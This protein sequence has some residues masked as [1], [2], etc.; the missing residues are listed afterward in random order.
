MKRLKFGRQKLTKRPNMVCQSGG[1]ART[2]LFVLLCYQAFS[3]SL[4]FWQQ[5][6]QAQ[7]W[8]GEVVV[9][10]PKQNSPAHLHAL[11]TKRPTLS[12][13][14]SKGMPQCLI[15]SFN[16]ARADFPSQTNQ[17]FCSEDDFFLHR[18]EPSFPLLFDQLCVHQFFRWP[19]DCFARTPP[20][21][22]SLKLFPFPIHRE[23]SFGVTAKA[24]TEENRHPVD[25]LCGDL[26]QQKSCLKD[27]WSNDR[28][29]N[30][31][32]FGGDTLATPI[33]VH[34]LLLPDFLLYL[35][36]PHWTCAG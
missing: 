29:Q 12:D 22:C 19:N 28:R 31:P 20:F 27:T 3:R 16:Q 15:D 32:V 4:F 2:S 5:D 21:A 24:I 8:S 1:H 23:Q 7:M 26:D 36:P 35:R 10:T 30:Q 33:V 6:P 9:A 25:H 18:F 13:Q 11:F 34:L 17:L 14:R